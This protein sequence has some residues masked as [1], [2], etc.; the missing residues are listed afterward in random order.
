[1]F[2]LVGV[3]L[4]FVLLSGCSKTN[5]TTVSFYYWKTVFKLSENEKQVLKENNVSKLY[6]RYFDVALKNGQPIP[7]SPI[8]FEEQPIG[9]IIVPVVYIKN[10]IFLREGT[11]LNNLANK[12]ADYVEQINNKNKIE[13]KEIQID[14]DWTLKSKEQYLKFIDIFKKRNNKLLS[15]TIRLHQIKY[16]RGTGTPN[17]DKGVLMYYNMGR[18]SPDSLNSIYDR[19]IAQRYI[20]SLKNYPL[21]LALALPIY[22]W[23]IQIRNNKVI[24]LINK[25]DASTFSNDTHFIETEKPFFEVKENV[26]KLGYYFQKGD[27]IKVES[28]SSDDIREMAND[29]SENIRETPSEV[30]FYDLDDFNFKNYKHER[31]FFEKVSSIF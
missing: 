11:D 9:M 17:V 19:A 4:I 31:K 28:I 2:R 7:I 15:A 5:Q 1:M 30:I 20:E 8:D 18:I 21:P 23:G 13:C 6:V 16:Y 12:I 10:E 25:T 26:I 24:A 3:A 27:R 22:S 14:C 29:L